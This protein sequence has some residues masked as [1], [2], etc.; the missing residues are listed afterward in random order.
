MH[1][2]SWSSP[3]K[4]PDAAC[5]SSDFVDCLMNRSTKKEF[6]V[7]AIQGAGQEPPSRNLCGTTF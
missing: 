7:A 2:E 3:G 6:S 5:N 1:L 4:N